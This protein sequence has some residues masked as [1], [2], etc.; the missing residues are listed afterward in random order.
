VLKWNAGLRYA[1]ASRGAAVLRQIA[2]KE[3]VP[4]QSFS[5]RADLSCG[6]TVGPLVAAQLAMEAIDCGA[7]MLAMHSAR[8][9]MAW[10]DQAGSIRLYGAFLAKA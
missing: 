5:M 9:T 10:G 2:A 8:E 6:S 7:P 1:T 4:L 3:G